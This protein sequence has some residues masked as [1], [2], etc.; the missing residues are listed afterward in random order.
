MPE[1]YVTHIKL[2]FCENAINLKRLQERY[3][4]S[5]PSFGD[6]MYDIMCCRMRLNTVNE[7]EVGLPNFG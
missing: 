1:K 7:W 4:V 5:M 6:E 3:I 2:S